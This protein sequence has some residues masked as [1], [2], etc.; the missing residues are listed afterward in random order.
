[1]AIA[2]KYRSQGLIVGTVQRN[3]VRL[4]DKVSVALLKSFDE[5]ALTDPH[6]VEEFLPLIREAFSQP[7][8]ISLD[9]DKRPSVTL[10]LLRYLESKVDDSK[11]KHD[12]EETISFASGPLAGRHV[13]AQ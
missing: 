9:V 10:L 8:F 5:S 2:L 12:V 6:N 11:V 7:Q 3:V 4:G 13:P 1:V